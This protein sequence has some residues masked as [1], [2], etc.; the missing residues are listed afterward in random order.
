MATINFNID[1][2]DLKALFITTRDS[3]KKGVNLKNWTNN[4]EANYEMYFER[5]IQLNQKPKTFT[6][7]INGQTLALT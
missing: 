5:Q 3:H 4:C 1:Q 6:Q 7:W 2:D